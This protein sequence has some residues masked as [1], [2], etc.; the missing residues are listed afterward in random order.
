MLAALVRFG[1]SAG[2]PLSSTQPGASVSSANAARLSPSARAVRPSAASEPIEFC[3]SRSPALHPS[4]CSRSNALPAIG[5]NS[6]NRFP[7]CQSWPLKHN[8]GMA[9]ASA[10]SVRFGYFVGSVQRLHLSSGSASKA[11]PNHSVE[12]TKCSKLQFAPHL[13]RVCRA[14]HES[15]WV[16]VPVPGISRAE[17]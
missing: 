8:T 13:E 5:K 10:A 1:S 9:L 16:K 11:L 4:A 12:A 7:S 14:W 2:C 15:R 6:E 3:R 17:G